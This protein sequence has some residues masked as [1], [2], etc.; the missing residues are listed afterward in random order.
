MAEDFAGFN[1]LSGRQTPAMLLAVT[2]KG[3]V[4]FTPDSLQD[5]RPSSPSSRDG[6]GGVDEGG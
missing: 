1:L 2:K 5:D 3:P 4:F 6:S